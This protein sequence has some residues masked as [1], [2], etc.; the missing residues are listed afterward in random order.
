MAW[1]FDRSETRE[2]QVQTNGLGAQCWAQPWLPPI[3]PISWCLWGMRLLLF[4]SKSTNWRSQRG[5]IRLWFGL[6]YSQ[7]KTIAN[8]SQESP[9]SFKFPGVQHSGEGLFSQSTVI[10]LSVCSVDI[11]SKD[12]LQFQ[13]YRSQFIGH[14]ITLF[15]AMR[16][17][18]I[19]EVFFG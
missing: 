17:Y 19:K 18:W 9:F 10:S 3:S 16:I 6:I 12:N 13:M 4:T 11:M 7:V 8:D 2:R 15:T 14:N 5:F 1:L